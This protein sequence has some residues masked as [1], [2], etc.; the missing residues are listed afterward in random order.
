M[1]AHLPGCKAKFPPKLG[2]GHTTDEA[3]VNERAR[4]LH[5]FFTAVLTDADFR[6]VAQMPAVHSQLCLEAAMSQ[7]LMDAHLRRRSYERQQTEGSDGSKA[8][9]LNVRSWGVT[10]NWTQYWCKL[11]ADGKITCHLPGETGRFSK[12]DLCPLVRPVRGAGVKHVAEVGSA[13]AGRPNCFEVVRGSY[14]WVAQ[15][16]DAEQ[17]QRWVHMIQ[18]PGERLPPHAML[19]TDDTRVVYGRPVLE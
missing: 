18:K 16:E 12:Y 1:P 10:W 19:A 3:R 17:C 2:A 15:A 8:G 6:Y 11:T 9:F 13:E 5:E 14:K 4:L 7:S